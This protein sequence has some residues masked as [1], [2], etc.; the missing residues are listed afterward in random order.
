GMPR[1]MRAATIEGQIMRVADLIAYVN[2]DID[3]AT[4]GGLLQPQ[5]LPADAIAALGT[6]ASAR[7]AALVK[8]VVTETLAR[9]LTDVLM[10]ERTWTAVLRVPSFLSEAV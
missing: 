4:R 2:H 10:S 5:D 3:D 8:D 6:T 7:I 1:E 9:A